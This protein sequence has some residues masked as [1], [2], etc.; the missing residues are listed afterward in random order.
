MG[1]EAPF[2]E[3][4]YRLAIVIP[5]EIKRKKSKDDFFWD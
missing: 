5:F 3:L 2:A 4:C 1:I